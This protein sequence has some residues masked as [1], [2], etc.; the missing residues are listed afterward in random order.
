MI[1]S[2]KLTAAGAALLAKVPAGSGAPVT[3]WQIGTG[4]LPAGTD[5]T[6]RTALA[7]PLKDLPIA[8]VTNSGSQSLVLGQFGNTGMDAFVWEE[9][10]LLAQDPD[11]VEILMGYGC[12]FGA[13][14]AIQAGEDQLREF[15]FGCQLIFSGETAVAAEIDRTLEFA[16]LK[17]LENYYTKGETLSPETRVLLGDV[18]TPDEAFLA[19]YGLAGS[20]VE[21]PPAVEPE[22]RRDGTYY[23]DRKVSYNRGV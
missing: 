21:M 1:P 16:T 19:L 11:E 6:A 7:E 8:R 3:R 10:G 20:I 14:E 23:L 9:L 2:V 5:L 17:D 15:V 18:N 4:V 13:G 22:D 12:A